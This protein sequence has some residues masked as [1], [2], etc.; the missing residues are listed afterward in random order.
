MDLTL[1]PDS[2]EAADG[3]LT[4]GG[5]RSSTLADEF[6]TPLVVYCEETIRARARQYRAAAPDAL[7]VYGTKAFPNVALMQLLGGEGL[8][9][10]VSTLGELRFAQR[11][12]IPG[13]RIV[14]HGNNKSDEELRAAADAR[15]AYVV[16]DSVEELERARA[17]RIE[18][19]LVR[20]TPG[21]EADTHES[22]RTGHLGSKFGVTPEE[23]ASLA[24]DVDGVHVHVGSQLL[25]LSSARET[26][27]WLNRYLDSTGWTPRVVDLGGGLGTPTQPGERAPSIAEF[28]ETLVGGLA[29]EAR[30]ILEPGRSLVGQAGVTLYRVGSV[31]RSGERAWVAVDGGTSDNARPQLYD[32]RYTAVVATRL[33]AAS[34]GTFGVAGKHCESG[35]VLIDDVALAEP[36]RG[37]LLAVPATGAYTLAMSSNYNAVPRP[38]AVLVS[39]GDARVIRRRETL[40]DVL[41][42]EV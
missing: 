22:I 13:E 34:S 42:F 31:K 4:I 17:A 18:R 8:G 32:A 1:F 38:A 3:E 12:G 26:I 41:S 14:V 24:Q 20:I 35:D 21:I 23:A 2:A 5:V 33:D 37:D 15:A 28:V 11:A 40:D 39:G 10:D 30:V 9:A 36:R 7:V 16:L 25:A 27:A 29:A 19:M 6:G